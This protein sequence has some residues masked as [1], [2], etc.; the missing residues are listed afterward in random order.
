[1]LLVCVEAGL[2]LSAAIERVGKEVGRS[3]PILAEQF[4]LVSLEMRARTAPGACASTGII[5]PT[6]LVACTARS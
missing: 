6:K 4:G 1:M 3:H 2:G 5:S